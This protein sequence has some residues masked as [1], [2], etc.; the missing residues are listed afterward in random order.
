MAADDDRDK[1]GRFVPGWKGGP[2]RQ[3]GNTPLHR[4]ITEEKA[5]HLWRERYDVAAGEVDPTN[6]HAVGRKDKA[7]EFVLLRRSGLPPAQKP[8]IPA[9]PWGKIRGIEDLREA[10]EGIY[11]MQEAGDLDG[12]QLEFVL[13]LIERTMKIFETL[14]LAPVV[15]E[16]QARIDEMRATG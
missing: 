12:T 16:L 11:S 7:A 6:E 13:S 9:L 10:V 8:D 2:G 3:P 1:K 5:E 4:A 14:E 15:R